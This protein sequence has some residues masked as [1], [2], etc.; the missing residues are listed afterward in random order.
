ML[1]SVFCN[2][3][4]VDSVLTTLKFNVLFDNVIKN[5]CSM[6]YVLCLIILLPSGQSRRSGPAWFC[7]S[8]R[9][10]KFSG[11]YLLPV[12]DYLQ[13]WLS[14]DVYAGAAGVRS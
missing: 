8:I 9:L 14:V 10:L 7:M 6:F 12:E 3:L 1:S 13:K 4:P 11:C 2:V 5:S